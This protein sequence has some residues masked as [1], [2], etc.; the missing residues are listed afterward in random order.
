[1]QFPAL[2]N[3]YSGVL[4]AFAE[5]DECEFEASNRKN[6][7]ALGSQHA[8]RTGHQVRCEQ[9]IGVTYNRKESVDRNYRR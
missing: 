8:R 7:L 2:T 4:D 5:C 6:A 3:R 1:M 9:S